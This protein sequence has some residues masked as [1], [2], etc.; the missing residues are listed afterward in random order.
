[1]YEHVESQG[2]LFWTPWQLTVYRGSCPN[3]VP[4]NFNLI[5]RQVSLLSGVS[6]IVSQIPCSEANEISI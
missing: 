5:L 3:F 6:A 4:V 2:S 1:M